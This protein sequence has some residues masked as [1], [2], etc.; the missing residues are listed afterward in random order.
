M[1][2][3]GFLAAAD[4]VRLGAALAVL[5][6]MMLWELAAP[7]RRNEIPRLIRWPNNLGIAALDAA[8]VRLVFPL[9][10]AGA[11]V[12][13]EARGAGL[14]HLL[15]V[16]GWAAVLAGV[17]ALDLAIYAQHR[18]FHA[19]PALWRLHRMHHADTELDATTGLRF[20]P[21]E[22]VLSMAVKIAVVVALGLPAMAVL[23]FEVILNATSLFNHANIRLPAPADAALRLVLVTP[24]MHRVHHSIIPVETDSNFGFNLPWWDR[25]FGTYRAQ[26]RDGHDAMT[27][28]IAAFRDPRERWLDRMLT[29]PFR[30]ARQDEEGG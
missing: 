9:L 18:V 10:A 14:L 22:I 6:A 27:L 30:T 23:I 12:W 19:V 2:L 29:Q 24:D 7:R 16:T 5:A 3:E 11:A 13:A 21:L 26:T 28:G 25:L 17:L 4:Q 15:G 20:H 1:G 8:I